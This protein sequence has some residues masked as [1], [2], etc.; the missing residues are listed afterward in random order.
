[1]DAT[2]PTPSRQPA[3]VLAFR[4]YEPTKQTQRPAPPAQ[5]PAQLAP[6][7][8]SAQRTP[9]AVQRLVAARVPGSIDF[10]PQVAQPSQPATLPLY[11]NPA[12]LN[13][14]ATGVESGRTLD[15][16]A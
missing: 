13:I 16:Q 9:S 8:H 4:A 1:M 12:Q 2:S 3:H 11:R 5:P 15:V 6:S 14:A 10:T 7:T